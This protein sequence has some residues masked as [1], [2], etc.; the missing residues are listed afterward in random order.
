MLQGLEALISK[1]IA[2]SQEK[3]QLKGGARYGLELLAE[4]IRSVA[5][6]WTPLHFRG[7]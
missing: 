2:R 5:R 6:C 4:I 3:L 1:L 7:G